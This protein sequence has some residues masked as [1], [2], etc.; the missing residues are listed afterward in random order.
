VAKSD[1]ALTD[2]VIDVAAAGTPANA[3]RVMAFSVSGIDLSGTGLDSNASL[4]AVAGG[5]NSTPTLT[6]LSTTSANTVL[7]FFNA[8][9][10]NVSGTYSA[11]PPT[12]FTLIDEAHDGRTGL[13]GFFE[14]VSSAQSSISISLSGSSNSHNWVVIGD[15]LLTLAAANVTP[16][17]DPR[18]VKIAQINDHGLTAKF[19]SA[20]GS[21]IVLD[22]DLTWKALPPGPANEFLQ[23]AGSGAALRYAVPAG[24]GVGLYSPLIGAVPTQASTGLGTWLNQG[25]ATAV[26]G[27]NGVSIRAPAE[28]T[29]KGAFTFRGLYKAA[30]ATPYSFKALIGLS[31]GG[32][33]WTKAGLGWFNP[34]TGK[35]QAIYLGSAAAADSGGAGSVYEVADFT[36][37]TTFNGVVTLNNGKSGA[38]VPFNG[39]PA[40]FK[41]RDDGTNIYV[42]LSASGGDDDFVEVYTVAKASGFL[43]STGYSDVMFFVSTQNNLDVVGTLF[44]LVQG[45]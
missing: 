29:Y 17:N 43:G 19:G 36:L 4:P 35:A 28:G 22:T 11:T 23:S 37:P 40:W 3:F 5:T 2:E 6:G 31:T 8:Q 33:S 13:E 30:P 14:N 21:L 32:L 15:A 24:S 7:L 1:D 18:W 44:A 39:N 12:G 9:N 41:I 26:D 10:N 34:G 27:V 20:V 45:T 42:Y 16:D 25:S 38:N